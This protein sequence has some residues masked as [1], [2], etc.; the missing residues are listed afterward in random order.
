[1]ISHFRASSEIISQQPTIAI[2]HVVLI[3]MN[4]HHAPCFD[5]LNFRIILNCI[6]SE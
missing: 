3:W 4:T 5:S 1:M 6:E 2:P